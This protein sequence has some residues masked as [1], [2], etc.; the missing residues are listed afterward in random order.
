MMLNCSQESL[1][2]HLRALK[3]QEALWKRLL[4][5]K[6]PRKPRF[7]PHCL[8]IE[9]IQVGLQPSAIVSPRCPALILSKNHHYPLPTTTAH[10]CTL[11]ILMVKGLQI[12]GLFTS[13]SI[14]Q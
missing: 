8:A 7:G 10:A 12:E 5:K 2:A 4:G 6:A 11:P 13:A 3:P 1:E 14:I 9:A